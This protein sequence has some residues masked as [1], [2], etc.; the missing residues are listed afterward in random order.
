[1]TRKFLNYSLLLF[2][3]FLVSVFVI[4]FSKVYFLKEPIIIDNYFSEN[5]K[6]FQSFLANKININENQIIIES[7][8]LEINDL[9]NFL[10]IKI[11]NLEIIT[12]SNETILKSNKINIKLSLLDL[13]EGLTN[14]QLLLENIFIDKIQFEFLRN[15]DFKII[16]SSILNFLR[17]VDDNNS[18]IFKNLKINQFNFKF[19]DQNSIL[20]SNLLFECKSLN[21]DVLN[22]Q[23]NFFLKCFETKTNSG[24]IVKNFNYNKNGIFV[25]GYFEKFNLRLLKF[26][27]YFKEFNFDGEFNSYFKINLNSNLNVEKFNFKI[28]NNSSLIKKVDEKPNLFKLAGLG[29]F[30]FQENKLNFKNFVV[31]NYILNGSIEEDGSK[32]KNNVKISFDKKRFDQ[33]DSYLYKVFVKNLFF[34]NKNFINSANKFSLKNLKSEILINS[35]FDIESQEF[36]NISLSSKGY[37]SSFINDKKI[38]DL[39]NVNANLNGFYDLKYENNEFDLKVSGKSEN[40]KIKFIKLDEIYDL[41]EIDYSINYNNNKLTINELNLINKGNRAMEVKSILLRNNQNFNFTDLKV[42]IFDIPAKYFTHFYSMKIKEN[43]LS[44]TV[45][46][47]K[48]V[49]SKI[50]ISNKKNT[51]EITNKNIEILD[52]NFKNLSINNY[53]IKFENL[54]LTKKTDDVFIGNSKLLIKKIPLNTSF[55]VNENGLI[56]AFGSINFNKDLKSLINKKTDFNIENS[57]LLK[58]EA[59]GNLNDKNF[60][61]RVRSTLEN[62]SFF[63]RVL[64]LN[65]NNIKK[66]FVDLN[67]VFKN[68]TLK[69][70]NNILINYDNNEFKSDFDFQESDL[71]KIS[72]INSKNFIAKSILV[73]KENN[74]LNI[75]IDGKLVDISHLT[76]DLINQRK[77]KDFDIKF[78]I[79]SNQII[80]NNKFS[81]SGNLTGTYKNKIFSS[82]AKGKIILG[83][84]TLLDAGQLTILVENGKYL[85]TGKGS[86]NSGKTKVKIISSSGGLPNVTFES[87]EGGKLLSALGFTEK[88]KSGKIKLKVNFLDKNLSKYQGFINAKKF[89]VINA[90]KIVKSLSSLS[91]SGIN[92]LFVGEGVGF[93]VGDAKFEKI[94]NELKFKKILINNQNLSIYLEGDYNLNSEIINFTGSIVPFTIVSKFI[95]VVPAVG[96]LLTGSNKKGFISGQFKLNGKVSDPEID[97]NIL[98]FS[99]GILRQIF[100]KDWLKESKD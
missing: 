86:L 29:S 65:A 92:S 23:E 24:V 15:Q 20:K 31:N 54:N 36:E 76:N 6:K 53:T 60:D 7:V 28:L 1:M 66:G 33:F 79:V 21:F 47:G 50:Y 13:I 83:S 98:S 71:L 32:L 58:F 63:H 61:I 39:L 78:D 57:N 40:V 41:S 49:N 87:Q 81:L 97:I 72:N 16:N 9:Q 68:G 75:K 5:K 25:D 22:N 67:L 69:K 95:S 46:A 48:I 90:P 55:E 93:S 45:D 35:T 11:S 77:V 56:R 82:L 80:L 18:N 38:D 44:F 43:K 73:Q 85:I 10:S 14:N 62:S 84:N 74:S 100:S 59:E 99:P 8:G 34:K 19:L 4:Y 27:N 26:K 70:I 64:N 2:A 42:N 88:I 51:S 3:F 52:L 94:G 37:Y 17:G 91:F 12:E 30:D 96:E 89:R